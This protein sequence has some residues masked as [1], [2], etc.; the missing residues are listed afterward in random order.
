MPLGLLLAAACSDDESTDE[1]PDGQI[2]YYEVNGDCGRS[3]EPLDCAE[4]GCSVSGDFPPACGCDGTIYDNFCEA[5]QAGVDLDDEGTCAVPPDRFACGPLQCLR[6]SEY[7]EE[8]ED[9]GERSEYECPSIPGDCVPAACDC[10]DPS[11]IGEIT[12]SESDGELFV[13]IAD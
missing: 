13:V 12:C 3:G 8:R 5:A 6:G 1:C 7:C 9:T 4:I 10:L 11:G 2:P